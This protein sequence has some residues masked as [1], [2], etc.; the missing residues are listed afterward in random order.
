MQLVRDL[1]G[2]LQATWAEWGDLYL[3]R[4][5]YSQQSAAQQL[6]I[7]LIGLAAIF[8]VI[9]SFGSRN[10]GHHRMALPAIVSRQGWSRLS[11]SRHGALILA[12]AGLPFFLLAFSDPRTTLTRSETTFTSRHISQRSYVS[13]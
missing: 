13:S 7:A 9:R 6:L 10:P 12:L 4:L 11:L 8:V 3:D 5:I 1:W 2:L